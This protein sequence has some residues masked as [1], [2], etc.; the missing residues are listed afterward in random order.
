MTKRRMK[1]GRSPAQRERAMHRAALRVAG[2]LHMMR[3][4]KLIEFC[5]HLLTYVE[6][7]K[8]RREP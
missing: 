2:K 4:E 5:Y 6:L 3:K 7:T 8:P 1:K